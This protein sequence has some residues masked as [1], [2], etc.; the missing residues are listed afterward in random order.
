MEISKDSLVFWSRFGSKT[1]S[2]SYRQSYRLCVVRWIDKLISVSNDWRRAN[3][4]LSTLFI[5]ARSVIK[6]V[7]RCV[8]AGWMRSVL[9]QLSVTDLARSVRAAVASRNYELLSLDEIFWQLEK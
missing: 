5:T 4:S 2:A 7:F 9:D 8:I 3:P 6:P 1:D